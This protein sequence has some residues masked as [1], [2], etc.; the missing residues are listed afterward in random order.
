MGAPSM[1]R[2]LP[3]TFPALPTFTPLDVQ[4]RKMK[5]MF[6]IHA[7]EYLAGLHIEKKFRHVNLSVQAKDTVW[8]IKMRRFTGTLPCPKQGSRWDFFRKI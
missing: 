4:S 5:P 3:R 2:I 1:R 6:S 7:G 8:R